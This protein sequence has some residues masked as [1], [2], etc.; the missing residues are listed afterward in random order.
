MQRV[1]SFRTIDHVM[2]LSSVATF[3]PYAVVKTIYGYDVQIQVASIAGYE[4][5]K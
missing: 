3:K 5:F 4:T 1:Y 2:M